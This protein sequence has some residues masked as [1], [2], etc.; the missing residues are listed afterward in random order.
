LG[1]GMGGAGLHYGSSPNRVW[2]HSKLLLKLENPA[3][4]KTVW[5]IANIVMTLHLSPPILT[6][7]NKL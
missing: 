6:L 7:Q 1:A 2:S 3:L 5:N 4:H